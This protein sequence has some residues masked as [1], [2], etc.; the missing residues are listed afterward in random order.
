MDLKVSSITITVLRMPSPSLYPLS[1]PSPS[2]SPH[3]E[4]RHIE[5]DAEH[6]IDIS[7]LSSE[8]QRSII[9]DLD[10]HVVLNLN[11][12]TAGA[13]NDLI[14]SGLAAAQVS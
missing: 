6:V 9:L 5:A 12:F 2:P 7:D 4:R 3:P 8:R 14:A 1:S 13:R 10:L 11:G